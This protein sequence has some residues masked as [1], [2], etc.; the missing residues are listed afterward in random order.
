MIHVKN[1]R[2]RRRNAHWVNH[3]D[4]AINDLMG[5]SLGDIV[6]KSLVQTQP[7]VNIIK[8]DKD[9]TLE[10]AIPG[11][12]KNDIDINVKEDSLIISSA[13]H[14]TSEVAKNKLENKEDEKKEEVVY[15]KRE[16]NYDSFN[17]SFTLPENIDHEGIKANFKNGLLLITLPKKEKMD[18]SRSIKIS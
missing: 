5:G 16:F 9:F 1:P 13:K 4:H 15:S 11:L 18:T 14:E 10:I 8:T 17:R 7:A 2:H 3:F 6:N 12:N